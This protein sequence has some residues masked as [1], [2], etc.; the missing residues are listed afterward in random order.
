MELIKNDKIPAAIRI[1][2]CAMLNNDDF[3]NRVTDRKLKDIIQ[4][5]MF[6]EYN[7]IANAN[8]SDEIF[9]NMYK[10]SK[11]EQLQNTHDT[12]TEI[13]EQYR[14]SFDSL[15]YFGCYEYAIGNKFLGMRIFEHIGNAK[16]KYPE[17]SKIDGDRENLD[18]LINLV[19]ELCK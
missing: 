13:I 11:K 18:D 12:Y 4:A 7:I 9:K 5:T 17:I 2:L 6:K 3:Y 1:N 14:G 16:L 19:M 8:E 15:L 10:K